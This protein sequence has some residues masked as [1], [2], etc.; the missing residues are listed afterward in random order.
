MPVPRTPTWIAVLAAI[1]A[2]TL[3]S[4]GNALPLDPVE[5]LNQALPLDDV[6]NPTE[7]MLQFRRANLKKKV[8]ALKTIGELRRALALD[9]WRDD[10]T[11]VVDDR[12]RRIDAELRPQVGER[13]TK[14]LEERAKS[15]D[16][17]LR[18]A[19]ANVITEIGP[20]VR[21]L[22]PGNEFGFARS[23][24][25]LVARLAT[26]QDLG[27]RQE[28]LRALGNLN[29]KPDDAIPIMT[30]VLEKDPAPGPRRLAADGLRQMVRVGTFLQKRRLAGAARDPVQEQAL[31]AEVNDTLRQVM[32]ASGIGLKDAD[33][34]VRTLI[35][36][37]WKLVAQT[38]ND[39]ISEPD[40][41]SKY[42]PPGRPLTPEENAEFAKKRNELTKEIDELRPICAAF[43]GQH[44]ALA[45]T[46]SDPDPAVRAAGADALVEAA[47]ARRRIRLR[48]LSVPHL[49]GDQRDPAKLLTGAD[50]LEAFLSADLTALAPLYS[51]TDVQLRKSA[52]V[53]L[54]LV[55]E[56]ALALLENVVAGTSD[57]DRLIR[58][59][60]AKTLSF[61]PPDKLT[62]AVPNLIQLLNDSDLD[63]RITA[64]GTL[65]GMGPLA[66][67]AAVA[68]G[69][70]ATRGDAD[71]R[72][73]AIH[74]LL[75]LGTEHGKAAV[76]HL[77]EVL[78]QRDAD[79]KAIATAA[80]ALGRFGAAAQTAIPALRRLIG[81]DDA[82]VRIQ[83]S[84]AILAI[85]AASP[86]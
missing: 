45:G 37:T 52:A 76:P 79:A 21:A 75:A 58:W 15:G 63:V 16:P 85:G 72:I 49:P 65:E 8:D 20:S 11:R 68:L 10:P 54:L 26:D 84:E 23:L 13:L 73:A 3:A 6:T 7:A 1:T 80:Y 28:A 42:P 78:G 64:A 36:E 53:T 77:I 44:T 12:I 31:R 55:E 29:A 43:S 51:A 32:Q 39:R 41:K 67:D 34:Q 4:P 46:L 17:S 82:E 59:A 48:V 61:F 19:T 2:L 47:I 38:L 9:E 56:R 25:P 33:A 71:G 70:A 27:V 69:Q 22:E 62:V 30:R 83:A 24:F 5:E 81:H 50:P 40:M 14:L 74:A 66:K 57:A 86:K 35:L 60:S 18:L